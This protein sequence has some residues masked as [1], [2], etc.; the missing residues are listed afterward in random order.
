MTIYEIFFYLFILLALR[1]IVGMER[2]DLFSPKKPRQEYNG[3][4]GDGLGKHI[5]FARKPRG[6]IRETFDRLERLNDYNVKT[7]KWRSFMIG[8]L[9][10]TI[11]ISIV[12]LRRIP[13][14]YEFATMMLCIFVAM[15]WL[16][17][18]YQYHY[19]NFANK[20]V[21]RNLCYLK[22]KLATLK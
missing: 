22:R 16:T 10:A 12:L 13:K 9:G 18:Y 11:L 19:H 2:Q 8:S 1:S 21:K 20:Y 3:P 7:V 17:H 15:T 14:P 5:Y 6:T 4:V